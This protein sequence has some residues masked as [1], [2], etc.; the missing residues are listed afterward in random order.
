M[1]WERVKDGVQSGRDSFGRGVEGFVEGVE[2]WTGLKVK[3]TFKAGKEVS[4]VKAREV[5]KAAE[6]K[7]EEA[8]VVVEKKVEEVKRRV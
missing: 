4:E 1:T 8:K 7:V 5:V 6:A 2:N 3:E